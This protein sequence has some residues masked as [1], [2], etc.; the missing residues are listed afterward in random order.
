MVGGGGATVR[1]LLQ[2]W[3]RYFEMLSLREM[4]NILPVQTLVR[5]IWLYRQ[6][7]MRFAYALPEL[8]VGYTERVRRIKKGQL[9]A[10]AHT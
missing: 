7:D 5:V 4:H 6:R 1:G 3:A 8:K 10:F 2:M 9:A